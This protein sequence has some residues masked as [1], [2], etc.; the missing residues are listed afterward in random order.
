MSITPVIRSEVKS[1][2]TLNVAFLVAN[3]VGIGL[4]LGLA[5][6][7]WRISSEHGV[8]PVSGEPFVWAFALPVL[9]AFLLTNA[10][11]AA[12]IRRSAELKR[13]LCWLVAGG[14]WLLAICVDFSHH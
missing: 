10:V 14:L 13:W 3:A 6:R 9:A 4:Y 12:L 11:W 1:L 8:I 5:S 2:R 7:G